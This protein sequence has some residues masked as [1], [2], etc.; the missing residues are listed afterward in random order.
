MAGAQRQAP[1]SP[2]GRLLRGRAH[3]MQ[4]LDVGSSPAL[5]LPF[6]VVT[7]TKPPGSTGQRAPLSP[8]S[9]ERER[10]VSKGQSVQPHVNPRN[11]WAG[12]QWLRWSCFWPPWRLPLCERGHRCNRLNLRLDGLSVRWGLTLRSSSKVPG[13]HSPSTRSWTECVFFQHLQ[14]KP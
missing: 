4:E 10:L 13:A 3:S 1:V 7:L 2:Q 8:S 11:P 14:V 5:P 9:H 6:K 12:G